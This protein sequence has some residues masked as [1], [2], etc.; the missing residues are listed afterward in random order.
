MKR[1]LIPVLAALSLPTAFYAEAKAEPEWV[2]IHKDKI[3]KWRDI[4]TFIDKNSLMISNDGIT[5]FA[6]GKVDNLYKKKYRGNEILKF[7][8]PTPFLLPTYWRGYDC[9]KRKEFYTP[10]SYK[11]NPLL[12]FTNKIFNT[13]EM[14]KKELK[15]EK[16]HIRNI[17]N[18][19]E[20]FKFVCLGNQ[21][22]RKANYDAL[23]ILHSK[24]PYEVSTTQYDL[25][26][27]NLTYNQYQSLMIKSKNENPNVKPYLIE[28]RIREK[29]DSDP[30]K[31]IN[32]IL[33]VTKESDEYKAYK[34]EIKREEQERLQ[35]LRKDEKNPQENKHQKCLKAADY[36][37]C[38]NYQNR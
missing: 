3:K 27:L 17:E 5:I 23:E 31:I 38:M 12:S 33:D 6:K 15:E 7:P 8:I 30:V 32:P 9:T 26:K 16:K 25:D 2:F 24:H 34:R 37:G 28:R 4:D 18:T 21:S 19:W 1:F 10:Y 29:I 22:K 20:E 11:R 13:D 35:N 14:S 36:K